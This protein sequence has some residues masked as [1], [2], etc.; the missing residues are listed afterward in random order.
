[1]GPASLGVPPR[2]HRL[3]DNGSD[4]LLELVGSWFCFAVAS[5]RLPSLAEAGQPPS[6]PFRPPILPTSRSSVVHCPG[7]W[8]VEIHMIL[9]CFVGLWIDVKAFRCI[10]LNRGPTLDLEPHER[11]SLPLDQ[12]RGRVLGGARPAGLGEAGR[13]GFSRI[14]AKFRTCCSCIQILTKT[15]GT[16]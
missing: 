15:C 11:V 9:G 12:S 2:V 14:L 6:G 13:P 10:Q 3:L 16:R 7:K 4:P 8:V 5:A 1:M